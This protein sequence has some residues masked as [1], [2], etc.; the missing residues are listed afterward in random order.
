MNDFVVAAVQAAPVHFD[1]D[2]STEKACQLIADAARKGAELAAFGETWLPGYPVHAHA[3]RSGKLWYEAAALY[4]DQAVEVPSETT[5]R[6]CQAA[7]KAGI[8]VVIGIVER[9]VHTQGTV[10][11]CQLF[12]SR[13]GEILGKH[14][15][16]KPTTN[17]RIVWG[18]GDG[19]DLTVFQRP[20]GRI[21]GLNCWEHIMLLPT[22][23]LAAQGTQ[24]HIASWP[25]FEPKDVPEPPQYVFARQ[26]LL[27]RAFAVQAA[28]YVICVA[29]L[30]RPDIDV[31]EKYRHMA[32][33][34]TG[35]SIIIDPRGE[36]I[37]GPVHGDE[38]IL[39]ARLSLDLVRAAKSVV[40]VA[41]HYSR[42]DVFQLLVHGE[43]AQSL[44]ESQ[45]RKPAKRTAPRE[46]PAETG[47]DERDT[48]A[49]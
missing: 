30:L 1:R 26:Q 9:D 32:S 48:E 41:G 18:Q 21:S 16:L 33:N 36:I 49:A 39:T 25:G 4:I 35:D 45:G 31:P 20:Y 15:K 11:C 44:Y 7:K 10:Y 23:A 40:D 37:A 14:R 28:C 2:A 43:P 24:I 19:T 6:L 13:D 5:E 38:E 34:D 3:P 22:Y 46:G 17:E 12:I 27:S 8:D 42:P 29:G 47:G